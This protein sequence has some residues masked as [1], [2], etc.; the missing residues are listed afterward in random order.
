LFIS[1]EFWSLDIVS[2]FGFRAS[3]LEPFDLLRPSRGALTEPSEPSFT[4]LNKDILLL[5]TPQLL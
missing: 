2:D 1:F 3:D 4:R 5:S